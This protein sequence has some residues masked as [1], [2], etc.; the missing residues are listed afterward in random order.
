MVKAPFLVLLSLVILFCAASAAVTVQTQTS[1]SVKEKN[2]TLELTHTSIQATISQGGTLVSHFD[3]TSTIGNLPLNFSVTATG[4]FANQTNF[5]G[6]SFFTLQPARSVKVNFTIIVPSDSALGA[7]DTTFVIN[8]TTGATKF[9]NVTII[10]IAKTTPPPSKG[11]GGGG[12]GGAGVIRI[13]IIKTPPLFDLDLRVINATLV[14]GEFLTIFVN[15]TNFGTSTEN[16]DAEITYTILD[17]EGNVLYTIMD[18]RAIG[19]GITYEKSFPN[20]ILPPGHYGIKIV[21]VYGENQKATAVQFFSVNKFS[22]V[23]LG[24][25]PQIST[26]TTDPIIWIILIVAL[27]WILSQRLKKKRHMRRYH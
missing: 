8:D 26:F 19:A 11:P 16:V 3:A 14:E 9:V 13:E 17:F 6:G 1:T 23:I 24:L 22:G 15:I 7:Y 4:D 10:V 18:T 20:A 5:T 2:A 25:P 21:T 12:G 27:M